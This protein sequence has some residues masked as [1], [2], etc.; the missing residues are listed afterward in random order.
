MSMREPGVS[1]EAFEARVLRIQD[2]HLPST[3][4]CFSLLCQRAE[5]RTARCDDGETCGAIEVLEVLATWIDCA[6]PGARAH[7]L[8]K[9]VP[10]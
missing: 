4:L 1:V 8:S 5:V 10:S 7:H 6:M 9:V 3:W 2:K